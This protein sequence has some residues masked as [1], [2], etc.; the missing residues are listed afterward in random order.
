MTKYEPLHRFLDAAQND[1]IAMTFAEIE[2]LIG[3]QLPPSARKHRAWWSNNPSNS[4]ITYAWLTAGYK[5]ENVDLEREKLVFRKM[6]QAESVDPG[7][8]AST[9]GATMTGARRPLI[10]FMKGLL[11]IAP[12]TDLTEPAD[13]EWA[14]KFKIGGFTHEDDR[15]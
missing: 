7:P 5:S 11:T 6:N 8:Q 2:D 4:V 12:G 3:T 15:K 13:P 1:R 9:D 10:G 14:E